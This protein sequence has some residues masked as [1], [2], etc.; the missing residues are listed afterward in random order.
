MGSHQAQYQSLSYAHEEGE[1]MAPRNML[2]AFCWVW[3]RSKLDLGIAGQLLQLQLQRGNPSDADANKR[4]QQ[5]LAQASSLSDLSD[6]VEHLGPHVAPGLLAGAAAHAANL[7]QVVL[8][9]LVERF[10][11]LCVNL[12]VC[13]YVRMCGCQEKRAI[14]AA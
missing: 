8:V 13:S 5:L 14:T 6:F 10:Y 3:L 9:V 1:L 11:S 12:C 2:P 7:L 4:A